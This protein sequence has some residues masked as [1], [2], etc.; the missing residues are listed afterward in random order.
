MTITWVQGKHRS[1]WSRTRHPVDSGAERSSGASRRRGVAG[2]RGR[3]MTGERL[4]TGFGMQEGWGSLG[5][6]SGPPAP[7]RR[8][9]RSGAWAPS[10]SGAQQR[11]SS[12]LEHA[13]E[14]RSE[15]HSSRRDSSSARATN[16]PGRSSA[17]GTQR[18]ATALIVIHPDGALGINVTSDLTPLSRCYRQQI[19]SPN[20]WSAPRPS[21]AHQVVHLP[22]WPTAQAAPT[23]P[24]GAVRRQKEALSWVLGD[25]AAYGGLDPCWTRR[26]RGMGAQ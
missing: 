16:R 14:V 9:P 6:L 17:P 1:W 8:S 3:R 7:I 23:R 11:G 19:C 2:M 10:S 20:F 15:H 22:R 26:Q 5:R 12:R 13:A 4:G 21:L 18:R 24:L 25:V